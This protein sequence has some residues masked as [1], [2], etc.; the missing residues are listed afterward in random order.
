MVVARA[1]CQKKTAC[2]AGQADVVVTDQSDEGVT[3]AGWSEA[4]EEARWAAAVVAGDSC[5]CLSRSVRMGVLT[6][7]RTPFALSLLDVPEERR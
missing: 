6:V 5:G 2:W 3:L 4:H 7:L 1:L